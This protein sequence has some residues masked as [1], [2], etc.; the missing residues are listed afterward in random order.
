MPSVIDPPEFV[1]YVETHA[2]AIDTPD[3]TSQVEPV[4]NSG[5]R[6]RI[7]SL[8]TSPLRLVSSTCLRTAR[9]SRSRRQLIC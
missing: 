7:Q 9:A 5:A 8:S 4:Q 2:L 1:A 6:W 3:G